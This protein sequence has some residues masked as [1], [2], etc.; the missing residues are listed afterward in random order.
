M[1]RKQMK[2]ENPKRIEEL[3][4]LKT[5]QKIGIEENQVVCDIGAGTG[6]FTIAAATMTRNT[7]YG[8]EIDKEMLNLI[9]AKAKQNDLTNIRLIE[10][11]GDHFAMED[12][13]VDIVLM[14]TV[15][16]EIDNKAAMLSEINRILRDDGKCAVIE[17]NRRDAQTGPPMDIRLDKPELETIFT[18]HGFRKIDNFDLG[19]DMYCM[20]FK[21][22]N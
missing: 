14:V 5:L 7:V 3:S 8:L 10:V 13:S 19:E 1:N 15:L 4:P 22:E 20:V 6:I 16:H 21:F 12:G 2:L 9:E 17:F 11:R 18:N